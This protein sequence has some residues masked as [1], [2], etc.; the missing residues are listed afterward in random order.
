MLRNCITELD[1]ALIFLNHPYENDPEDPQG[2]PG[3]PWGLQGTPGTPLGPPGDA[4]G[5]SR[6][7]WDP[8]RTKNRTYLS[9]STTPEALDCCVQTCLLGPIA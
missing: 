6:E 9:K 3:A 4:P 7:S 5:T 8:P 1:K 2:A